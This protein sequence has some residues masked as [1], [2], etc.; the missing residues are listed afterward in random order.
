MHPAS[1]PGYVGPV[2]AGVLGVS[3]EQLILKLL[4]PAL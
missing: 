4:P 2:Y 3:A 1:E